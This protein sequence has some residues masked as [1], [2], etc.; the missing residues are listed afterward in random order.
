MNE[1]MEALGREIDNLD[2]L[3]HAIHLPMPAQF[4][5]DQL[6]AALPKKVAALRAV[7]VRLTGEN[8]WEV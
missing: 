2:N 4:H 5:V 8:P 6:K 1:D 7:F 3:S